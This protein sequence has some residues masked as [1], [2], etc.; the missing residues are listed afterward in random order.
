MNNKK[1][2][3]TNQKKN[4]DHDKIKRLE[5]TIQDIESSL[6]YRIGRTL[7]SPIRIIRDTPKI[8]AATKYELELKNNK[9]RR[10]LKDKGVV[11]I[12][13]KRILKSHKKL[14]GL[15][16]L[17]TNKN[18]KTIISLTS[19]PERIDDLYYNLYSLLNQT[20]KPDILILWLAED[21]FP[22]K[23]LDLPIEII[24]LKKKG[25]IINWCTDLKSYKKLI[26]SLKEFPDDII[27]TAD[28]D[29]YYPENW[30]ELLYFSY[31]KNPKNIHCH[32]AHKVT[33]NSDSSLAPYLQWPKC[34][35]DKT[36]SHLNF[37]TTGGGVLFPPKS[38]HKTV[39]NEELFQQLCPTA[40]DIW[41]WG[42]ALLN[43]TN[44]SI[45]K[46][47]ITN[48]IFVNPELEHGLTD[49]TTLYDINKTANDTQ[50][51]NLISHFDNI[52]NTIKLKSI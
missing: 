8:I 51:R 40:D 2:S 48:I 5:S 38:L 22:N 30:L 44:I 31:L 16:P 26:F 15:P 43:E 33:L 18:P 19:F 35:S 34:I 42:M 10:L 9:N 45:I 36:P 4:N 6:S 12:N 3:P 32:R 11:F 24:K 50:I 49:G 13:K 52:R 28:D 25:L 39:L 23:E 37:F 21:Q 20:M 46:D 27:V 17:D 41:F 29:I 7:T 47:N 14:K 1:S